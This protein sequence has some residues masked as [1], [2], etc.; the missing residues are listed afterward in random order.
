MSS[1][2]RRARRGRL[3]PVLALLALLAL[4]TLSAG[5]ALAAGP[6][7]ARASVDRQT[8]TLGDP[9]QLTVVVD[10]AADHQIVDPGVAR[11]IGDFELIE[12]LPAQQ[13][14]QGAG[15]R[16]V[17]RYRLTSFRLGDRVVP[18]IEV[19][20]V[21]P[22]GVRGVARTEPQPI[23]VASVARP[24]ED[25]SDI[26]PLKPQLEVPGAPP[27]STELLLALVGAALFAIAV[28]A[29]FRLLQQLMAQSPPPEVLTP[30]Q[31]ALRELDR[32]TALRLPEAGQYKTHYELVSACLRRYAL[33]EFGLAAPQRTTRELLAELERSGAAVERA[34]MLR[35]VLSESDVVRFDHL[36][37]GPE[38][39]RDVVR[40]AGDA[41]TGGTP[42][43][44][45]AVGAEK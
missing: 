27:V 6:V 17:F 42:P 10:A 13:E 16:L 37:P 4:C 38:R 8:I 41:L 34:A 24:G 40:I 39:A 45:V 1:S 11:V 44:T 22:K 18:A 2:L 15:T 26:K 7:E 20:Y 14:T 31:R 23:S 28:I 5:A 25:V 12:T 9:F 29:C 21:D 33:E 36:L 3:A 30:A 19:G 32:I 35:E 43:R